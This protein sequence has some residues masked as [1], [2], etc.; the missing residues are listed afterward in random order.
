MKKI[1]LKLSE[2]LMFVVIFNLVGIAQTT[3]PTWLN[4]KPLNEWFEI[5][6]TSGGGGAAVDAW[7]G[8][9]VRE[10]SSQLFFAAS[11]GHSDSYDN[12]VVSIK[13]TDNAP[14]WILRCAPTP[15]SDLVWDTAYYKDGKPGSRH[16][17]HSNHW[18]PAVNRV[19]MFSLRGTWPAAHYYPT[20]DGFNPTTNTWDPAGTWSNIQGN[21]GMIREQNSSYVWTTGLYRWDPSTDT[22]SSP[23][24]TK[25][26]TQVRFPAAHD[27]KRNQLFTLQLGDGMGYNKAAGLQASRIPVTGNTQYV[28]TINDS[29]AKTQ[30][31]T[32]WPTYS[33]MDYDPEN[34]RF[35]FYC[36]QGTGAGRIY[37]IT[38]NSGNAW[39][40]SILQLGPESVIPTAIPSAGINR[41]FS[42]IPALKGFVMFPKASGNLYFIRTA[43]I[44][45]TEVSGIEYLLEDITVFPNPSTVFHVALNSKY[46]GE[47][48]LSLRNT[49]GQIV[50]QENLNKTASYLESTINL[51][52]EAKGVYFLQV[53]TSNGS[54]VQQLIKLEDR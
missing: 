53:Q 20:V 26:N 28:V 49:L 38:P 8:W 16:I 51:E 29:P 54:S 39:D 45:T 3:I 6:G 46:T 19:M 36:G 21:Y 11:G 5:P 13:L 32:D 7:G 40:M 2:I 33:A 37:V 14:K 30:F 9:A 43:P 47:V 31:M 25:T 34:D 22:Y 4:G 50:K 27:T 15:T 12:R 24:T 35:L 23:I 42:Y 1:I 48:I 41:R 18:I 10:D 52:G 17:Y 44:V